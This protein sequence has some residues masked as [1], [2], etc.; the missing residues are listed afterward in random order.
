MKILPT[1][2][3]EP[4]YTTSSPVYRV[5]LWEESGEAWALDAYVLLEASDVFEA[6]SWLNSK[7]HDGPYELFVEADESDETGFLEPRASSLLRLAGTNPNEGEV[8]EIGR[9][10]PLV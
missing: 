6:L 1:V 7:R 5:N 8:V 3:A 4:E 10:A 9:F 2:H